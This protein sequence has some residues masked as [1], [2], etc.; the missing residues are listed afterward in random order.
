[1][2]E[3]TI[4]GPAYWAAAVPVS[5]KMPAPMIAPMPSVVRFSAPRARFKVCVPSSAPA[6]VCSTAILF[7]VQIPIRFSPETGGFGRLKAGGKLL[8]HSDYCQ[9]NPLHPNVR[10]ILTNNKAE[11]HYPYRVIVLGRIVGRFSR[12]HDVV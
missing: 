10:N 5:T 11:L 12:D 1:M 4:A 8:S 9:G 7:L 6:S 2:K 3:Y